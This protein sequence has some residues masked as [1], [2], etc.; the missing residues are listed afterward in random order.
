MPLDLT[1]SVI[2]AQ[3]RER[4]RESRGHLEGRSSRGSHN[5]D[6]TSS[7]SLSHHSRAKDGRRFSYSSSST[8]M[9]AVVEEAMHHQTRTREEFLAC[10]ALQ[11]IL[12]PMAA[13]PLVASTAGLETSQSLSA[14]EPAFALPRH[15]SPCASMHSSAERGKGQN[16]GA[17]REK[18]REREKETSI[19]SSVRRALCA[20]VA[21]REGERED[22]GE[23]ETPVAA[24][25]PERERERTQVETSSSLDITRRDRERE[26]DRDAR[27]MGL[28]EIDT[29]KSSSSVRLAPLDIGFNSC[30]REVGVE[31]VLL[32]TKGAQAG[33][34]VSERESGRDT[35]DE[36]AAPL[37]LPECKPIPQSAMRTKHQKQRRPSSF[38]PVGVATTTSTPPTSPTWREAE[39]ERD[40][41]GQGEHSFIGQAGS[42]L[43]TS[44][45]SSSGDIIP[46]PSGSY[47]VPRVPSTQNIANTGDRVSAPIRIPQAARTNIIRSAAARSTAL[48]RSGVLKP[49]SL[50]ES[51][52]EK[53]PLS[54]SP[55]VERLRAHMD[56]L[57][58]QAEY[59]KWMRS[60][61]PKGKEEDLSQ[62]V[63]WGSEAIQ[64]EYRQ[65]EALDKDH[66]RLARLGGPQTIHSPSRYRG[67]TAAEADRPMGMVS[68]AL[69]PCALLQGLAYIT[70]NP[71][72]TLWA[73]LALTLSLFVLGVYSMNAVTKIMTPGQG[74]ECSTWLLAS[75]D[76]S[77]PSRMAVS[78]AHIA[79]TFT[80]RRIHR[81]YVS[82][83]PDACPRAKNKDPYAQGGE[84]SRFSLGCVWCLIETVLERQLYL[85]GLVVGGVVGSLLSLLMPVHGE[86]SE[87]DLPLW[88][89][90]VAMMLG[91]VLVTK[92]IMMAYAYTIAGQ[93]RERGALAGMLGNLAMA[94]GA[95]ANYS[96]GWLVHTDEQM[97]LST[98]SPFESHLWT[99]LALLGPVVIILFNAVSDLLFPLY[100]STFFGVA[101]N[102]SAPMASGYGCLAVVYGTIAACM[103]ERM[104]HLLWALPLVMVVGSRLT[105]NLGTLGI[106][107]SPTSSL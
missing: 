31:R 16:G 12:K 93:P 5:S 6:K 106:S 25:A 61:R 36:A 90:T 13:S 29:T 81:R 67:W 26:R 94:V 88:G 55:H 76:A 14:H 19:L 43:T 38:K 10:S 63:L 20:K 18:E 37:S 44:L 58:R 73:F 62:S 30:G 60:P 66:R 86:E 45:S 9:A 84:R 92:V 49:Q 99:W 22:E 70:G 52:L 77:L 59:T 102:Y 80:G 32:T 40:R 79:K 35:T 7:H 71:A 33:D 72:Y 28:L 57:A 41:D 42:I 15:T 34:Q 1:A 46:E 24:E 96:F 75:W 54:P 50:K 82:R 56:T 104:L 69:V 85:V 83:T 95:L 98:M 8:N 91:H 11:R 100:R 87:D 101:F 47:P 2:I 39:R 97:S 21:Q 103:H 78:S 4:E 27:G 89:I 65:K 17:E 68:L 105:T 107:D 3:E 48:S 53:V 74:K 23:R 51:L 64:E